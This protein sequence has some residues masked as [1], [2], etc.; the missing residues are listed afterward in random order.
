SE[1]IIWECFPHLTENLIS[2]LLSHPADHVVFFYNKKDCSRQEGTGP[3]SKP[4]GSTKK[5]VQAAIAKKLF[6]TD[7]TYGVICM[8]LKSRKNCPGCIEPSHYVGLKSTGA[9]ISPGDPAH[10]NLMCKSH[11]SSVFPY[12]EDC[13]AMWCSNP[14][15]NSR[16]FNSPPSADCSGNFLSFTK[17]GGASTGSQLPTVPNDSH[18][19]QEELMRDNQPG[20]SLAQEHDDIPDEQPDDWGVN[21]NVEMRGV[22]EDFKGQ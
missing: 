13:N 12:F 11:L 3:Q 6:E 16:P 20:D 8:C 17:H 1:L 10:Q 9:G 14:L 21:P 4:S 2:W 5:L 19:P 7:P 22:D 18:D 15:Y